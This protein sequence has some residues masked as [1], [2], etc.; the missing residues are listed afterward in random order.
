MEWKLKACP[1][2]GGDI[3]LDWEQHAWYEDCLQCGYT[4]VLQ[5]I[6]EVRE[7]VNKD[8]LKQAEFKK[9]TAEKEKK[10]VRL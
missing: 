2:C 6:V 1:R 9:Q 7:K 8:N 5:S 4:R 10:L 3:F